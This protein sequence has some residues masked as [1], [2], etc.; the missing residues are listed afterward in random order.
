MHSSKSAQTQDKQEILKSKKTK[1][2]KN[3]W[4]AKKC[5]F[6]KCNTG[7]HWYWFIADVLNHEREEVTLFFPGPHKVIILCACAISRAHDQDG[8][9]TVLVK[10]FILAC[11]RPFG[12]GG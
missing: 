11:I 8:V 3:T 6:H 4:K 7:K 1:R 2:K 5:N 12:I 10:L 9:P